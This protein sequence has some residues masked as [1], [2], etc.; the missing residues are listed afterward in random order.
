MSSVQIADSRKF[1]FFIIENNVLDAYS[2][3]S[4]AI[5][6]Y[7]SISRCANKGQCSFSLDYLAKQVKIG[8]ATFVR[9]LKEL[10]DSEL[11]SVQTP[12]GGKNVYTL[13]PVTKSIRVADDTPAQMELPPA[14]PDSPTRLTLSLPPA[15][16]EPH[17]NTNLRKLKTLPSGEGEESTTKP[18]K[19]LHA[20][21]QE[22][23]F[24]CHRKSYDC[25]PSWNGREAKALSDLIAATPSWKLSTYQILIRN[26]Y[27][28]DGL[29]GDRPGTWIPNL[30]RY[31][32]GPLDV[33]N[34]PKYKH[35]E[36]KQKT[37]SQTFR[38]SF[39]D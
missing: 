22:C 11:V 31:A 29:N 20:E 13:L 4:N 38:E 7:V 36:E 9:A 32:A 14:Q 28:S 25:D 21:I 3:S 23:I 39:N 37:A 10:E 6:A 35:K 12:V 19:S 2:I 30:S 5:L 34:R 24:S 26:R 27:A 15:H 8:R 17:K 1:G 33:Y 18:P 16:T